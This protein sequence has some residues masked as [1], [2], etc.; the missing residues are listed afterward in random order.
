MKGKLQYSI[1]TSAIINVCVC[2][3]EREREREG[4]TE[5]ER[6]DLNVDFTY[7]PKEIPFFF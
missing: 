3:R 6:G 2:E 5:K 1:I 7:Y 4:K